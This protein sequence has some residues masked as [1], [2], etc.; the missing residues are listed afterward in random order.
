ME[1][2]FT[3]PNFTLGLRF[4]AEDRLPRGMLVAAWPCSKVGIVTD[5]QNGAGGVQE[6]AEFDI[7]IRLGRSHRIFKTAFL[8]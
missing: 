6:V 4:E 3:D 5:A 7:F 8:A 2:E 1:F